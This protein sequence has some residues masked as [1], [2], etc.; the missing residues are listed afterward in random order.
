M[1]P[2]MKTTANAATPPTGRTTALIGSVIANRTALILVPVH[3]FAFAILYWGMTRLI[4]AEVLSTH[5]E[6]ARVMVTEAINSLHPLMKAPDHT[7]IPTSLID[8]VDAHKL[9]DL[10]I[11]HPDGSL[12]GHP[13]QPYPEVKTFLNHS[14]EEKFYF[15]R[16]G[17]IT[18]LIGIRKIRAMGSCVECHPQN[19][20]LAAVTIDLDLTPEVTAAHDRLGRNAVF[21]V[22][23]W[24][25]L[26]GGIN[27]GVRKWTRRSLAQLRRLE[28]DPV[29]SQIVANG[30]MSSVLLDPVATELYRSLTDIL[31]Q[32]REQ[33]KTLSDQLH[34]TDRLASLGRLAAGLAHEIKNPLAGIRGVME[35]MRDDADE[36]ESAKLFEQIVSELDRVNGTIHALLHFAKPTP[37]KRELVDVRCLIEESVSLIRPSL[38]K[39]KI[40]LL[41]E[42]AGTVGLFSLDPQQMRQVLTN[43]VANAADAIGD[44]GRIVVRASTFPDGPGL[45]ISVED[46]GPGIPAANL[47][48]VFEPFFT[49]K[50]SGTG[51]GLPV[52]RSQIDQHDGRIEVESEVGRGTTFFVILP[53][54]DDGTIDVPS[55]GPETRG[56]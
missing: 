25:L 13:G 14:R 55:N 53:Q 52:V 43:L 42:V 48:R 22:G 7:T 35:L 34:H 26:V 15:E 1:I 9:L 19:K 46:D 39:K 47:D 41:I 44:D 8:F 24:V 50:F 18:A 2:K 54:E 20:V 49:T 45:I 29:G 40:R 10:R 33:R 5:I 6:G 32:Q 36:E 17:S 30:Q 3:L 37:P 4:R 11:F 12:I 31:Q 38:A 56:N 23:G 28:S 27:F 51:L 16:R 21:L